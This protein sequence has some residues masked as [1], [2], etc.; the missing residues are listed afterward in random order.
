MSEIRSE[1]IAED[2][3]RAETNIDGPTAPMVLDGPIDGARLQA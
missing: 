2:S 3:G 1:W